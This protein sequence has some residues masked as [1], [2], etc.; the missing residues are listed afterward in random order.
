MEQERK[1]LLHVMALV[2]SSDT[3]VQRQDAEE[4][5]HAR[6]TLSHLPF[7]RKKPKRQPG[8]QPCLRL[9][10]H[11]TYHLQTLSL[12]EPSSVLPVPSLQTFLYPRLST[13][14]GK[15]H[16][17]LSNIST[18]LV[19]TK[20]QWPVSNVR[21]TLIPGK[22]GPTR[23]SPWYPLRRCR[24]RVLITKSSMVPIC[25]RNQASSI[26]EAQRDVKTA[27]WSRSKVVR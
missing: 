3:L 18:L 10:P 2:E 25:L 5:F 14:K 22:L 1:S 15:I 17:P 23:E 19:R 20:A 9:F 24:T 12:D 4:L 16:R 8:V 21:A 11:R 27:G 6:L 13:D 26:V 7:T